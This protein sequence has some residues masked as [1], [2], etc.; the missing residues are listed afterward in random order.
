MQW[1]VKFPVCEWVCTTRVFAYIFTGQACL[2]QALKA[3]IGALLA[4]PFNIIY[5]CMNV[6][7]IA[8]RIGRMEK[9]LL[10]VVCVFFS[11]A[12]LSFSILHIG[13]QVYKVSLGCVLSHFLCVSCA[14]AIV[15]KTSP[16]NVRKNIVCVCVGE[17]KASEIM[18]EKHKQKR[19]H[20]HI[21]FVV[22]DKVYFLPFSDSQNNRF[23]FP[24]GALPIYA[25]HVDTAMR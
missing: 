20:T 16:E 11:S 4:V 22:H 9:K 24:M 5:I 18:S 19:T 14:F 1:F 3:S 2:N 10:C 15:R 21:R 7:C 6:L 13:L 17:E 12:C 23:F 8:N 25:A